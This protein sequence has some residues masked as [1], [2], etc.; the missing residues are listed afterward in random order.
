MT[1]SK[2][3]LINLVIT[4]LYCVLYGFMNITSVSEQ[5][6]CKQRNHLNSYK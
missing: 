2:T 1:L 5:V 6:Y 3:L 4:I